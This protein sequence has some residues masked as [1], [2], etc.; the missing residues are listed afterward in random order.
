V[1]YI[2][3]AIPAQVGAAYIKISNVQLNVLCRGNDGVFSWRVK[4]TNVLVIPSS[5][6]SSFQINGC[7]TRHHGGERSM[8]A[9]L[10]LAYEFRSVS[11]LTWR[12]AL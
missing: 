9:L 4:P 12:F 1:L 5:H 2:E 11:P 6:S 8:G 7:T 3:R 10:A